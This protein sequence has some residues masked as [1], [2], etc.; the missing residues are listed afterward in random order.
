MRLTHFGSASHDA[1]PPPGMRNGNQVCTKNSCSLLCYNN[2]RCRPV[3]AH[4]ARTTSTPTAT[5]ALA[6][7]ENDGCMRACDE[8][9]AETAQRDATWHIGSG[10]PAATMY[11]ALGLLRDRCRSEEGTTWQ[12]PRG[13]IPHACVGGNI[14]AG[15]SPPNR[16]CSPRYSS[17]CHY[18]ASRCIV[19]AVQER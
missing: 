5:C 13:G 12:G 8:K 15:E 4:G 19:S 14:T 3:S 16:A 10:R 11:L 17:A 1:L 6:D 2:L 18:T 9:S 7:A